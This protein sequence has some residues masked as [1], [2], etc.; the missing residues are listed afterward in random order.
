[1]IGAEGFSNQII[2]KLKEL[3][4]KTYLTKVDS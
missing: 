2:D 4:I 1:V 3:R